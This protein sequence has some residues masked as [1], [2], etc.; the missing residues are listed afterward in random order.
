LP[1]LDGRKNATLYLHFPC[2][3]GVVSAV[4][5]SSF[6]EKVHGWTVETL[7]PVNYDIK[8]QWLNK[9]LPEHSAVVDFLYHPQA[10]FWADHHSTTFLTTEAKADFERRRSPWLLYDKERGS[11]ASLLWS[12]LCEHFSADTNFEE[13]VCWAEKIDS[14]SY[15]S[16]EEAIS[17]HHP[18]IVLTRSL[19]IEPDQAYLE[20]LVSGLQRHSLREIAET[21]EVRRRFD[22]AESRNVRGLKYIGKN[23]HLVGEVALFSVE[24]NGAFLNRYA[25]YHF[26]P[27]AHYSIGVVRFDNSTKI[28]AMRNPWLKFESVNLGGFMKRFGGG[29]HQRVGSVILP[30]DQADTINQ[31]VSDLLRFTSETNLK[32]TA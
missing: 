23:I 22:E 32:V 10:E 21:N 1:I 27:K 4:L 19:A 13:M 25:P 8:D 31:V 15:D 9:V 14:A 20:F 28:T 3:D 18:A 16:V 29:G 26:F 5:A 6:L 24:N 2:F 7:E 11:C 12:H 30:N 17:S